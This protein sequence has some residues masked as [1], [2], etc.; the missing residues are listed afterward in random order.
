[1]KQEIDRVK[2]K[3]ALSLANDLGKEANSLSYGISPYSEA[4]MAAAAAVAT[5][6]DVQSPKR[7]RRE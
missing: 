2:L 3:R 5:L 6:S 4:E 1:V 7:Q